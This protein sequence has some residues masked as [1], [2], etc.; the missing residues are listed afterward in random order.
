MSEAMTTDNY[1]DILAATESLEVLLKNGAA[2]VTY[3]IPRSDVGTLCRTLAILQ[4]A[5]SNA[6]RRRA[7]QAAERQSV[8]MSRGFVEGCAVPITDDEGEGRT[9]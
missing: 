6:F 9:Q 5:E 2:S 4:H 1:A 3:G 7:Q 8:P